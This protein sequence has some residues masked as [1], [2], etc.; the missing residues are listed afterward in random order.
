MFLMFL[1]VFGYICLCLSGVSFAASLGLA[2]FS[3][4]K[5]GF[6]V[7]VIYLSMFL[8]MLAFV[9]FYHS[10]GSQ[11]WATVLFYTICIFFQFIW[12]GKLRHQASRI[13][14]WAF[15][16]TLFTSGFLL[17]AMILMNASLALQ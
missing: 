17:G 10:S 8:L 12:V 11:A 6:L 2:I 16:T 1:I 15:V 9:F 5:K 7:P 3:R 14:K 13:L 4:N